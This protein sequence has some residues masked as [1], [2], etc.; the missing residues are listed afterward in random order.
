MGKQALFGKPAL[1]AGGAHGTVVLAAIYMQG[2]RERCEVG[3]LCRGKGT[4]ESL[5]PFLLIYFE[6]SS[7]TALLEKSLAQTLTTGVRALSFAPSWEVN[8]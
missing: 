6:L 5:T 4:Y 2:C 3:D 1:S 7:W 8:F